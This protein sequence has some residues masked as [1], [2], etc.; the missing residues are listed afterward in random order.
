MLWDA[1]QQRP[2]KKYAVLVP[3]SGGRDSTYVMYNAVQR[4]GKR[5]LA[6]HFDNDFQ[7]PQAQKNFLHA[8]Q[9]L[10]IDHLVVKS[11]YGLPTKIVQ[12]AVKAALPFSVFD[13]TTNCCVACTYGYR[14]AAYREAITQ[15]IP[16]ILWGDSDAEA[17]SFSYRA[18][19][20]K[21]FF[22]RQWHHYLLFIL[23]TMLFQFEFW[24]PKSRFFHLSAP[25]YNGDGVQDL[26]FFDYVT[27]DRRTIKKTIT[28]ELGWSVPPESVTTWRFDCTIHHLVN[29]CFKHAYGF[30]KDFDGFANMVRAGKM[31]Q[32]EALEQ[33]EAIGWMDEE[34]A[35]ILKED[36]KL[37]RTE[38][39]KYFGYVE[40]RES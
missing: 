30:S 18:N 24:I 4:F 27:W 36:L 19:R 20:L 23:Y 38:L 3:A 13:I 12:Q 6:L 31:E 9:T 7:V 37:S 29:Y 1:I 14:A 28:K 5:V 11:K 2:G 33:E 26:H 34:L 35:R 16:T 17:I 21:F 39:S 40:N 15:G 22:S 8:A 32:V 25:T 10:G